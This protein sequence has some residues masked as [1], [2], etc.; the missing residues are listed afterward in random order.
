[1]SDALTDE[2]VIFDAADSADGVAITGEIDR[3]DPGD[4]VIRLEAGCNELWLNYAEA[5]A[6]RDYLTRAVP[7]I[8]RGGEDG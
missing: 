6:V 7:L 3:S 8:E 1:M 4:P 5:C 2:R